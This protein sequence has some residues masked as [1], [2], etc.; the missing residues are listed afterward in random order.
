M[1]ISILL[2]DGD[3]SYKL[4][5]LGMYLIAIVLSFSFHE[6]AHAHA[7]FRNGDP[8]ARNLGRMTLNPIAHIDPIGFLMII[9]VGFGWAKPVPVNPR[10]YKSYRKAEFQVSMAGIFTNIIIS[11]ISAFLYIAAFTIESVTKVEIPEMVY[12]FLSIMGYLNAGLAVFN[13]IPVYPL[14]GFHLFELIFGR[15]FPKAVLWMH[16]HG[17]IVLYV[18]FG[19][20]FVLS[21]F[22]GIS[23]VGTVSEF[24]FDGSIRLFWLIAKLFIH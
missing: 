19:L 23:I 6:W 20:S 22:F 8:T 11:M 16:N 7:A 17:R 4:V 10:N 24:I 5:Y 1:L 18:I 9:I 3:L 12:T 14:D 13:F 2:G 15:K 21:R